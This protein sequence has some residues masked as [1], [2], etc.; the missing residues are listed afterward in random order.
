MTPMPA[1]STASAFEY[2]Y[3]KSIVTHEMVD[4]HF[5]QLSMPSKPHAKNYFICNDGGSL[6]GAATLPECLMQE[7]ELAKDARSLYWIEER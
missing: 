3:V 4:G 2:G 5:F 7:A 6:G 1:K